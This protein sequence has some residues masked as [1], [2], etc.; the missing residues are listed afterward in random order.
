MA[1][2]VF[3]EVVTVAD[4]RAGLSRTLRGFRKSTSASPVVLGSHRKPEAVLLPFSVYQKLLTA[5]DAHGAQSM[6]DD[7]RSR[8]EL[9]SR[10]AQVNR[11]R[12]V[13]VFGSVARGDETADSDI[14]LLVEPD[15]EASLFDLAQFGIDMEQLLGR[16]V[17]VV[18]S[19]ALIDG[20]DR[21]IL[22]QAIPL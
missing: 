17:D 7:L 18:S 9:I 8:R 16:E 19:R 20:V 3:D 22:Q 12:S 1:S 15:D 10:L 14:D 13:S 4:A 21:H 11:L 2:K 6:L 5:G